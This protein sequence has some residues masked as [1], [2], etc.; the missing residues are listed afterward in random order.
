[1]KKKNKGLHRTQHDTITAN[2]QGA[3]PAP[4]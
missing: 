4:I 3:L 1:M 2:Q